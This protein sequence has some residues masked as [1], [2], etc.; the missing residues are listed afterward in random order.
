MSTEPV[1]V[2]SLGIGWWSDVLAAMARPP[3]EAA[4]QP[5]CRRRALSGQMGVLPTQCCQ[6]L[7][8]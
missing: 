1:R 5:G 6:Q 8:A 2:A 3:L 4:F 7:G